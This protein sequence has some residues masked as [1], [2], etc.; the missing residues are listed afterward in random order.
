MVQHQQKLV[1]I[2]DV[3]NIPAAGAQ[4]VATGF[5]INADNN[6]SLAVARQECTVE[7]NGGDPGG[8]FRWWLTAITTA[9]F[10]LN[11]AGANPGVCNL[12]CVSHVFHSICFDISSEQQMY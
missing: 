11:W 7:A 5:L 9:G 3:N 12:R 8:T 2:A 1:H 4:A 6:P 10:I